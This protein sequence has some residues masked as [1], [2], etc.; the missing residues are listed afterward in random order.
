MRYLICS[1]CSCRCTKERQCVIVLQSKFNWRSYDH[2]LKIMSHFGQERFKFDSLIQ[3]WFMYLFPCH[4]IKY[5]ILFK[6]QSRSL[7]M[8]FN[9]SPF[10]PLDARRPQ[11]CTSWCIIGWPSLQ[12][13][14]VVGPNTITFSF[15]NQLTIYFNP[16]VTNELLYN[17]AS[18]LKHQFNF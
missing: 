2:Y 3:E 14:H 9:W 16:N 7:K 12:V 6:C 8:I 15:L 18:R 5:S 10:L 11:N 13:L 1:F 17:F 4:F